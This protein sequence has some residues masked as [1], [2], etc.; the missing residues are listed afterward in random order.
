MITQGKESP[1]CGPTALV[2]AFELLGKKH[3]LTKVI[4]ACGETVGGSDE[5]TLMRAA[6]EL[7]FVCHQIGTHRS[8]AA[9]E[10]VR[11]VRS[12]VLCI[13]SWSHWVTVHGLKD[14][15]LVIDPEKKMPHV[16]GWRALRNRWELSAAEQSRPRDWSFFGI[17]LF[18]E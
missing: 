11:E 4:E 14:R 10:W 15:V 16:M 7:G 6:D 18:V 2:N 1:L 17:A 12:A 9:W 8:K 3:T 5:F 13:D